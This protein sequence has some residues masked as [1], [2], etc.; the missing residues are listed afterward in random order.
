MP[1]SRNPSEYPIKIRPS[2]IGDLAKRF[3]YRP[4]NLGHVPKDLMS[5]KDAPHQLAQLGS[6]LERYVPALPDQLTPERIVAN[7]ERYGEGAWCEQRW[8][9]DYRAH[10]PT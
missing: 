8:I 4:W 3:R 10:L 1:W 5:D 9:E 7:I 6:A 2:E